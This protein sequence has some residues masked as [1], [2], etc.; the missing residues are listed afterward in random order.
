MRGYIVLGKK[1]SDTKRL[2][3]IITVFLTNELYS[4]LQRSEGDP[5]T[6]RL[7]TYE[8]R[9]NGVLTEK[10]RDRQ[11]NLI[12]TMTDDSS[13]ATDKQAHTAT[14]IAVPSRAPLARPKN[15]SSDSQHTRGCSVAGDQ[16]EC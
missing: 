16:T 9:G 10:S 8:D 12:P 5:T 13:K 7:S 14:I 6:I 4:F 11:P 15:H 2:I 1:P 3:Y